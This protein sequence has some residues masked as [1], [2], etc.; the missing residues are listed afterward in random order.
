MDMDEDDSAFSP[1]DFLG[2]TAAQDGDMS[3][4][5][6]FD[7]DDMDVTDVISAAIR[8]RRSSIAPPPLSSVNP[9]LSR[10][11]LG[12]VTSV[13]EEEDITRSAQTDSEEDN[14]RSSQFTEG[15][16]M[17]DTQGS[18]PMEFTIPL[19]QS[20]NPAEKDE[21][22][23][24]LRAVT[25]SGQEPHEPQASDDEFG[26]NDPG[27]PLDNAMQRLRA[28]RA[29][30]PSQENEEQAREDSFVSTDES[31]ESAGRP[32]A[33]IN[34]TKARASLGEEK[35]MEMATVI[36][37]QPPVAP[38]SQ[39][40]PPS[41]LPVFQPQTRSA[42]FSAPPPAI[43]G[44]SSSSPKKIFPSATISTPFQFAEPPKSPARDRPERAS[45]ISPRKGNPG[46]NTLGS[47]ISPRK[48]PADVEDDHQSSPA[49]RRAVGSTS[50]PRPLSPSKRAAFEE[51]P[52]GSGSAASLRRPAGYLAR[53]KSVATVDNSFNV[54]SELRK[55][56]GRASIAGP[57]A[58]DAWKRFDR[59]VGPFQKASTNQP[60]QRASQTETVVEAVRR[61]V[62]FASSARRSTSP[63][64]H[65]M[66]QDDTGEVAIQAAMEMTA[67]WRDGVEQQED[68][69]EDVVSTK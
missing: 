60:Q 12:V 7:G 47:I 25:H 37:D 65:E 2:G 29:S 57:P 17:D 30:I 10:V 32:D 11:P 40:P 41:R 24:A 20:L 48:R 56:A 43:W 66:E 14:T 34:L 51:P 58:G 13:A 55:T 39:E 49:K 42:I 38:V 45:S 61:P 59:N 19:A 33:T 28:A 54:P 46:V 64:Q 69:D 67:Q 4:D 35:F 68:E 36:L 52:S 23:R 22:W 26:A 44:A 27:M 1:S 8:R 6:Y 50:T 15:G 3:E 63:A 31:F 18:G 62:T 16:D 9:A 5:G 53:R 21:T